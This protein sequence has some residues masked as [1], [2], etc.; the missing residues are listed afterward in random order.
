M[1]VDGNF[2]DLPAGSLSGIVLGALASA[3][4]EPK[5]KA[6][7]AQSGV[8]LAVQR[9]VILPNRYGLTLKKVCFG[10]AC[11]GKHAGCNDTSGCSIDFMLPAA[12][13]DASIRPGRIPMSII[14]AVKT[15]SIGATTAYP[16]VSAFEYTKLAH[17][18]IIRNLTKNATIG[19]VVRFDRPLR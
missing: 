11:I 7:A 10:L 17:D 1:V 4:T 2:I 6:L 12:G 5:V 13:E 14:K 8:P 16:I 3:E 15:L 18:E 9:A 19:P